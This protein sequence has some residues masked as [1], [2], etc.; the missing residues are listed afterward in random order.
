M[1]TNSVETK[2]LEHLQVIHHGLAVGRQVQPIG[3]ES[4]IQSGHQKGKFA[5]EKRSLDAVD[6][7]DLDAAECCIAA[8]GVVAHGYS[9]VV[10]IG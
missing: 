7:S 1:F 4:L 2:A 9:D 5:I 10:E 8:D 6:F 3:P